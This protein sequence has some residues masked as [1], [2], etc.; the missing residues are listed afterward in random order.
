MHFSVFLTFSWALF[1]LVT[2]RSVPETSNLPARRSYKSITSA[3]SLVKRDDYSDAVEKGKDLWA[4]LQAHCDRE[5]VDPS[6]AK[7]KGELKWDVMDADKEDADDSEPADGSKEKLD[8]LGIDTCTP[9]WQRY[10]NSPF[11]LVDGESI[12]S[13]FANSYG[14]QAGV[15]IAEDIK[16]IKGSPIAWSTVTALIWEDTCKNVDKT[17][18]KS[19]QYIF[20]DNIVNPETKVFIDKVGMGKTFKPGQ[21]GFFALLGSVNGKG[22]AYLLLQHSGIIGKKTIKQIVTYKAEDGAYQMYL[23][24]EEWKQATAPGPCTSTNTP[25]DD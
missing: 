15:I 19:L 1:A 5:V 25:N 4:L 7:L 2:S 17:D 21:E 24:F 13:Q 6:L 10:A 22:T 9:F 16:R 8:E 11:Q 18:P 3:P 12:R 20:Q 23:E 14:T